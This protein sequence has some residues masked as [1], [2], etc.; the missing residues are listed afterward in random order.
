MFYKK[1]KISFLFWFIYTALSTAMLCNVAVSLLNKLELSPYLAF[2]A[3]AIVL[4]WCGCL[5]LLLHKISGDNDR[6]EF[7][8]FLKSFFAGLV[9]VLLAGAGI[10]L[11]L[12]GIAEPGQSAYVR[13]ALITAGYHQ[14]SNSHGASYLYVAFLHEIFFLFGNHLLPAAVIQSVFQVIGFAV[15]YFGIR[16][17]YGRLAGLL[18]FAILCFSETMIEKAAGLGSPITI[19]FFVFACGFSLICL[20]AKLKFSYVSAVLCAII[21]AL[22]TYLDASGILLFA[23]SIALLFTVSRRRVTTARKRIILAAVTVLTYLVSYVLAVFAD[24]AASNKSFLTVLLSGLSQFKPRGLY[25]ENLDFNIDAAI[26]IAVVLACMG[27]FAFWRRPVRENMLPLGVLSGVTAVLVGCG[28]LNTSMYP[29]YFI[30][31]IAAISGARGFVECLAPAEYE[32]YMASKEEPLEESEPEK[33]TGVQ[34]E[35]VEKTEKQLKKEA[36]QAAKARSRE[37]KAKEKAEQRKKRSLQKIEAQLEAKRTKAAKQAEKEAKAAQKKAA[38]TEKK[39]ASNDEYYQKKVDETTGETIKYL[40]NPLPL[41]KKSQKKKSDY[42]ISDVPEND[43]YDY[44]VSDDDDFD[45]E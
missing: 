1:T 8:G 5:A 2:P 33:G 45:F 24:S 23:L 40:E 15:F 29:G 38:N 20:L 21:A 30:I 7:D 19:Y 4:C 11:R 25:L 31:C 27:A 41:P 13:D 35:P 36:K 42:P 18:S 17:L 43:D 28:I 32:E 3:A 37:A 39:S 44:A 34:Q 14:P 26:I 22:V 16:I 6:F 12:R 9:L 10:W